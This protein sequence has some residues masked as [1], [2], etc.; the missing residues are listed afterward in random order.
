MSSS[1]AFYLGAGLGF[2]ALGVLVSLVWAIT[3]W[4]EN[5]AKAQQNLKSKYQTIQMNAYCEIELSAEEM[6][7][8]HKQVAYAE[9]KVSGRSRSL[10]AELAKRDVLL[11]GRRNCHSLRRNEIWRRAILCRPPVTNQCSETGLLPT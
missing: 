3:V 2:A 5:R 4:H 10:M 9:K 11:I 8:L 7:L 1:R 6:A